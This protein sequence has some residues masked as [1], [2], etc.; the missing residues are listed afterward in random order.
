MS[1]YELLRFYWVWL[2]FLESSRGGVNGAA[3]ATE[4]IVAEI[5]LVIWL[6][7]GAVYIDKLKGLNGVNH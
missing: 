4:L 6:L 5:V 2:R 3:F 1:I 7:V